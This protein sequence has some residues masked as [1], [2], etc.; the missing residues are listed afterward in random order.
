MTNFL[1]GQEIDV[2]AF[3]DGLPS[4]EEIRILSRGNSI[5]KGTE[6]ETVGGGCC[7]CG[8]SYAALGSVTCPL[9]T[10]YRALSLFYEFFEPH[11]S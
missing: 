1:V 10:S 3:R 9:L 4:T 8:K 7:S 11:S 6:N 2:S 5:C